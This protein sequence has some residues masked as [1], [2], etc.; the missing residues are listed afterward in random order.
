MDQFIDAFLNAGGTVITARREQARQIRYDYAL[1]KRAAGQ[2]AWPSPNVRAWSPW[3]EQLAESLLWTRSDTMPPGSAIL[4]PWQEQALWERVMRRSPDTK[5]LYNLSATARLAQAARRLIHE[6]RLPDPASL[7]TAD[8]NTRAWLGWHAAYEKRLESSNWRDSAKLTEL[9]TSAVRDKRVPVPRHIAAVGFVQFSPAQ[10]ELLDAFRDA[11]TVVEAPE[12][13]RIDGTVRRMAFRDSSEELHAAANWV[14]RLLSRDPT[15]RI[16]VAMPNLARQRSTVERVFDD[17]L[18]PGS[19][20]PGQGSFVRPYRISTGESLLAY[21]LI[22]AAL[23]ILQF[24]DKRSDIEEFSRLLRSP[25]VHAVAREHPDRASIDLWLREEGVGEF[26]V[27]SLPYLITRFFDRAGKRT[28]LTVLKSIFEKLTG[29][30][31]ASSRMQAPS[32]WAARF[33]KVLDLFGWPGERALLPV[34]QRVADVFQ[35]ILSQFASLDAV[36]ASITLERARQ[37][38]VQMLSNTTFQPYP[39]STPVQILTPSECNGLVFDH[40]WVAGLHAET[41][42]EMPT[43]NPFLPFSWLRDNGVPGATAEKQLQTA[44]RITQNLLGCAHNILVSH[45]LRD[46]HRELQPSPLLPPS[47]QTLSEDPG[48]IE[49]R[50]Y[51]EFLIASSALEVIS[52]DRGP[53]PQLG[54]AQIGGSRVFQLQAACPFRAFTELRL[55]AR[56]WPQ[57]HPG[58]DAKARGMLSHSALEILFNHISDSDVL[59]ATVTGR[60]FRDQVVDAA[61]KALERLER[62]RP[63]KLN[64]HHRLLEHTRL[65]VMLLDWLRLESQRPAFVR[66]GTE[67]RRKVEIAGLKVKVS[68]DRIDDVPGHGRVIID[69]KSGAHRPSEWLGPRPDEP[70]LPLYA[71]SEKEP[72]AAVLF[73]QLLPAQP[74]FSGVAASSEIVPGVKAFDDLRIT[75]RTGLTWDTLKDEWRDVLFALAREF[76]A[77]DA[78]ID[79]KK[80][81]NT[82]RNCHLSTVCRIGENVG[83]AAHE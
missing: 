25:F 71:L 55:G 35:R 21:P 29:E 80:G 32:V 56:P 17:V 27:E 50:T 30:I 46:Q 82:C 64:E 22:D 75:G 19:V 5:G 23:L 20:L 58:L 44:H 62:R 38:L 6:W 43:A 42:P 54:A 16:A 57:S 77:G 67:I 41:W 47:H 10:H 39:G 78:R 15:S 53:K 24:L 69:Y 9:V 8:E 13:A 83:V 74:A 18:L 7:R 40:L 73:G 66:I 45:P 26:F 14:R 81:S 65:T 52:D 49:A 2:R 28:R 61:D 4:K 68:V 34:E 63:T 1:S 11:G 31:Q 3:L 79:P 48:L 76:M 12:A 51:R 70:Q 37:Q 60:S 59:R 36:M 33:R 72:L